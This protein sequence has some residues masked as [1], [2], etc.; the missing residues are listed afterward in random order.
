MYFSAKITGFNLHTILTRGVQFFVIIGRMFP[1]AWEYSSNIWQP[2]IDTI[3]MSLLGSLL[4]SILV[5]PFAIVASS[6]IVKNKW[7][8]SLSRLFLSVVRTLPTLV[9]ALIATYIFGLGT[10]AGTFAIAT[11]TFAY[12]G[13]QL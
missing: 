4:G 6:N 3:K 1:P 7:I 5:I 11:Y 8:I 2:L 10:M 13:K 9:T 12:C